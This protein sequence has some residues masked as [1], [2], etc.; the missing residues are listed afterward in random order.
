MAFIC[1]AYYFTQM[2]DSNEPER[3]VSSFYATNFT[4]PGTSLYRLA[5]SELPEKITKASACAAKFVS[6]EAPSGN[7]RGVCLNCAGLIVIS[8]IEN[9]GKL[10]LVGFESGGCAYMNASASV[11]A[12]K[13]RGADLRS[14]GSAVEQISK[15]C[16]EKELG[17]FPD[18]RSECLQGVIDAF[19]A[20]ISD[21]S[22]RS[23]DEFPGEQ[24]LVCTCFGITEDRLFAAIK[25]RN[26]ADVES[27][28]DTCNAGSGCGSCRMLIQEYID[29]YVDESHH[30]S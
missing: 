9:N 13:F 3:S 29:A 1:T 28:A 19:R 14:F 11:I 7:G 10:D 6:P 16:V 5:V 25:T 20:A 8:I 12:E 18:E 22:S 21:H 23:V 26:A 2:I 15:A 30:T 24:A 27:V 4:S 17:I